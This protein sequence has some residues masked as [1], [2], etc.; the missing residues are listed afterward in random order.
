MKELT[1]LEGR[2]QKLKY[3]ERLQRQWTGR[4]VIDG[5]GSTE[6]HVG[7]YVWDHMLQMSQLS[8]RKLRTYFSGFWL[9]ERTAH[10]HIY[11][12]NLSGPWKNTLEI[13]I[14]VHL[15]KYCAGETDGEA[16]ENL[17][18][19]LRF[20]SEC[21]YSHWVSIRL[22]AHWMDLETT[23]TRFM[24]IRTLF[25]GIVAFTHWSFSV[26][27]LHA[28]RVLCECYAWVRTARAA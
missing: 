3:V 14:L 4:D 7:L 28:L 23:Q 12:L 6:G 1:K 13:L 16:G 5:G 19:K 25:W 17:D 21:N 15:E 18:K 24:F 26:H 8:Q 20:V 9:G 2:E 11:S 10:L 27:T 22:I